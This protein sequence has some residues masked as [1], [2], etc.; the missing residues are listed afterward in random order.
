MSQG[1]GG[2]ERSGREK[3]RIYI[4]AFIIALA[5]DY[6]VSL[7]RGMPY[8]PSLIGLAIMITSVLYF[9]WSWLRDR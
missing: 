8:Q 7:S 3:R 9:G 5:I 1:D 6:I 2:G 4:A